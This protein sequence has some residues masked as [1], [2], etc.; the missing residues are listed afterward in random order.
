M[1]DVLI[2][3]ATQLSTATAVAALYANATMHLLQG[4]VAFNELTT[5]ANLQAEEADYGGYGN[6]AL[7]TIPPPFPDSINGGASFMVPTTNFQVAGNSTVGNNIVGGWVQNANGTQLLMA[8]Q[9]AAW[10]MQNPLNALPVECLLNFY[11]DVNATIQY[12]GVPQ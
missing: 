11:G 6:V 5:I 4:N 9:S 10:S 8:W 2:P 7:V 12:A 1:A 3:Q